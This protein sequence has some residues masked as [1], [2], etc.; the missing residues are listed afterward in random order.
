M[1]PETLARLLTL[2]IIGALLWVVSDVVYGVCVALY[3]F[4]MPQ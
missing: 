2:A 4:G 3:R 1:K